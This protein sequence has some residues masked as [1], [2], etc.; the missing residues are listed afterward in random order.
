MCFEKR[1][2]S[3]AQKRKQK[4]EEEAHIQKL[5]KIISFFVA[6]SGVSAVPPTSGDN[7]NPPSSTGRVIVSIDTEAV[8]IYMSTTETSSVLSNNPTLWHTHDSKLTD[9]C[10]R[11]GLGACKNHDGNYLVFGI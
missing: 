10:V 3:G 2:A 7:E 1:F 8:L 4:E 11:C 9:Y 5:S 6:T